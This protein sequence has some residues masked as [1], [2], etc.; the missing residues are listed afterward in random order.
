MATNHGPDGS[1]L[2]L[3]DKKERFRFKKRNNLGGT[4]RSKSP[5]P[6]HHFLVY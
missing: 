3:K 6:I 5:V 2:S 4:A 1:G